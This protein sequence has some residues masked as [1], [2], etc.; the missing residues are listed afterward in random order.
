MK[1]IY[2]V[3]VDGVGECPHIRRINAECT[4]KIFTTND[5]EKVLK[6]CRQCPQL[7]KGYS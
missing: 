7:V 6:V 2:G 4:L 1:C 3:V 5:I